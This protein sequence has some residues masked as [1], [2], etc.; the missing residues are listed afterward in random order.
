MNAPDHPSLRSPRFSRRGFVQRVALGSAASTAFSAIAENGAKTPLDR[1]V[2]FGLI[3][4]IHPDVL[5]DGLARVQAFVS[6]MK[7]SRVDRARRNSAGAQELSGRAGT[8]RARK[9]TNRAAL[10]RDAAT[11]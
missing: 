8:Q 2:R 11:G 1:R 3:T 10:S 9:G 4:D 5:P 6:A 7:Q